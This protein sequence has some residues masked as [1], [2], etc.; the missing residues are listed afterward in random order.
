MH[1]GPSS[2]P[3]VVVRS[4]PRLTMVTVIVAPSTAALTGF[5]GKSLLRRVSDPSLMCRTVTRSSVTLRSCSQTRQVP[6]SS[7]P[8][9]A[10]SARAAALGGA[11]PAPAPAPACCAAEAPITVGKADLAIHAMTKAV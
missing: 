11:L 1:V 2:L 5:V 8:T 4:A 6:S 9:W 10:L 7:P 3:I